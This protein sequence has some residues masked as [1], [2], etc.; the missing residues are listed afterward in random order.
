MDKIIIQD[1][2]VRCVI[3]VFPHERH[4]PRDVLVNLTL[5]CDLAPAAA[6]DRLEDAIDYKALKFRIVE[7]AEK[8]AFKLVETMAES[9]ARLVLE[10]PGVDYVK[11]RVD[12]PGAL[13][14][15]RSVGVEIERPKP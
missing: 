6:S 4:H 3:G 12:K 1:L 9:I 5:F 7:L 10:T 11:V 14:Y 2:L 8:S 15:A 13:T